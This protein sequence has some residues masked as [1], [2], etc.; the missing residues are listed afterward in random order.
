MEG[1][2]NVKPGDVWRGRLILD[3]PGQFAN[4]DLVANTLRSMGAAQVWVWK[5]ANAETFPTDWPSNKLDDV[6]D[7]FEV[8][9]FVQLRVGGTPFDPEQQYPTS[10]QNWRIHDAWKY[11]EGTGIEPVGPVPPIPVDPGDPGD[12][13]DPGDLDTWTAGEPTPVPV[14]STPGDI[15]D[16]SER[17]STQLDIWAPRVI[18][19]AYMIVMGKYP[20]PQAL[21]AIQAVGRQEGWYGWAGKPS[22]WPGHHNW[23]AITC[24]CGGPPECKGGFAAGDGFYVNGKWTPYQT[25][26]AHRDT[27]LDG[28]IHLVETLILKRPKVQEVMDSGNLTAF[29]RAMRDTTYFCRTTG[30]GAN[31][32]PC[33][34]CATDDEKQGDA[35]WY[36]KFLDTGCAKIAANTGLPQVCF[37]SGPD[38]KDQKLPDPA[39]PP[40]EQVY[41]PPPRAR[42]TVGGAIAAAT[43]AAV[44]VGASVVMVRNHRG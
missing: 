37:L 24:G 23:G 34:S 2:L 44:S 13:I 5:D 16:Y 6:S 35:L 28:A 41:V 20:T 40:P 10:G 38:P 12:T 22:Q 27:N 9:W 31:G 14:K 7:L 32:Q 29:A 19:A 42:Y 21:Q 4:A 26:F 39:K 11:A 17:P 8:Q 33:C 36:A 43:L 1:T 15:G 25:C 30:K 18:R 3:G